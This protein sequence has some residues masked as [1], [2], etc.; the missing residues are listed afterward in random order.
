MAAR[1]HI[2]H[3]ISQTYAWAVI[4]A[5]ERLRY[6]TPTP[7]TIPDQEYDIGEWF[8]FAGGVV[9]IVDTTVWCAGRLW[10]Y[11]RSYRL[12]YTSDDGQDVRETTAYREDLHRLEDGSIALNG[13]SLRAKQQR[14]PNPCEVC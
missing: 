9:E 5:D 1:Q 8:T 10:G 4:E 11:D 2:T 6:T 3:K 14:R 12:R 7:M 13:D